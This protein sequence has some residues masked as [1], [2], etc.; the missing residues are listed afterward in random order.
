MSAV[1]H[2]DAIVQQ[3][4]A[5][6]RAYTGT[7]QQTNGALR[8]LFSL[9]AGATF[10]QVERVGMAIQ[11][12][13]DAAQSYDAV[14]TIAM[15]EMPNV[16]DSL[17]DTGAREKVIDINIFAAHRVARADE[18]LAFNPSGAAAR[19]A[20]PQREQVILA[21]A[22]DVEAALSATPDLMNLNHLAVLTEMPGRN[23][24]FWVDRWDALQLVMRVVF[25]H[26]RG[27]S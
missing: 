18:W 27:D 15:V 14:D 19:A 21:L 8:T 1:S 25:K 5:Q 24:N 17:L 13:W 9:G 7:T 22:Y 12:E 4:V 20:E 2:V 23:F 6:L 10:D 16:S 3:I 26:T 11:D